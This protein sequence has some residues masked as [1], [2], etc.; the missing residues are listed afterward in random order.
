VKSYEWKFLYGPAKAKA[1]FSD[2]MP[3]TIW[4]CNRRGNR[5]F[6]FHEPEAIWV[7][8]TYKLIGHAPRFDGS[9]LLVY[10]EVDDEVSVAQ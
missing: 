2:E 7:E 9:A 5:W 1:V 10:G 6:T 3:A 4:L 8:A